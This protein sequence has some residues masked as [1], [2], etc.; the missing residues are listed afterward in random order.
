MAWLS[1]ED[2]AERGDDVFL[3]LPDIFNDFHYFPICQ[4]LQPPVAVTG[5]RLVK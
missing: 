2:V 3:S 4:L 1:V 5:W